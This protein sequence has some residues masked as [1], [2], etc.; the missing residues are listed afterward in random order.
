VNVRISDFLTIDV[1][2]PMSD[3]SHLEIEKSTLEGRP[4][5]TGGGRTVNAN[6]IDILVTWLINRDRGAFLQGG[7]S[8]ATQPGSTTFPYVRPGNKNMLS[9]TRSAEL[10]A[11]AQ[12]VWQAIG[13]L[14]V[15][16][17]RWWHSLRSQA[18]AQGNCVA[19]KRLTEKS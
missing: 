10:K 8:Q 6:V 3:K 11:T 17:I 12:E 7:A 2:K 1:A 5:T 16:G 14:E 15:Y 18:T 13:G 4:Y 9:V 19:L